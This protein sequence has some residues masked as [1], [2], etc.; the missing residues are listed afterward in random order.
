MSLERQIARWRE[1]G[2]AGFWHWIEDVQPMIQATRGWT[3]Y[4]APSAR[5]KAEIDAALSGA[6][7]T[8]VFCW[9]RRHGKTVVAC[10]IAMWRWMAFGAQQIGVVSNS[11][12]QT[13]D[14]SFRLMRQVIERTPFL[15]KML[16]AGVIE[17]SATEI[18]LPKVGATITAL[19]SNPAQLYG[20]K[21]SVGMISELHASRTDEAYQTIASSTI[22]TAGS[23]VLIDSTVGPKTSPLYGLYQAATS[24]KDP[25]ICFSHIWYRDLEHAVAEGPAWIDEQRLRSRAAQMLPAEFAMM[26]CN[27]WT[28]GSSSVF[29]E[30]VIARCTAERYA[31]DPAVL[32]DGRAYAVGIGLDRALLFSMNG[33]KTVVGCVAKMTDE[34]GEPIFYVLEARALPFSTEAAVKRA[35]VDLKAK[36]GATHICVERYESSDLAAWAGTQKLDAEMTH[37]TSREQQEVFTTMATA[38]AEG[39]LKVHPAFE[40]LIRE[41][42]A[43]QYEIATDGNRGVVAK[44]SHPKGGHDDHVFAVAWAIHSLREQHL[45]PYQISGITCDAHAATA[46]HCILNGGQLVP[47]C[48]GECPSFNAVRGLYGKFAA[49]VPRAMRLEDF[50][51]LR[52]RN[53]GAHVRRR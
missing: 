37:A 43:F 6:Y 44:F 16:R 50:V 45:D 23:L 3:V 53:T 35:I 8:I 18:K 21:L 7:S 10:L 28:D 33:D 51:K 41:M 19:T 39:R 30:A 12:Q 29:P 38:A 34:A 49:K 15:S 13:S 25:S 9:P 32:A 22:D 42:A 36:F 5:I 46:Q 17:V 48:S 26:H 4:S 20:R 40:G 14:T 11:A 2:S 47:L 52:L 31:L 27:Q 1:P 24:G